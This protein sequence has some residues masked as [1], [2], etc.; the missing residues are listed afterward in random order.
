MRVRIQT[1]PKGGGGVEVHIIFSSRKY[2]TT[3]NFPGGGLG[4]PDPRSLSVST[5]IKVSISFNSH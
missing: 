2:M 3:C 1:T 5:H 4:A